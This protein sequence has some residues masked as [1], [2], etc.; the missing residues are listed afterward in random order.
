MTYHSMD[1][2]LWSSWLAPVVISK[3]QLIT[4]NSQFRTKQKVEFSFWNIFFFIWTTVAVVSLTKFR[5][6]PYTW[7]TDLKYEYGSRVVFSKSNTLF[8]VC[9]SSFW[10]PFQFF[11]RFSS[12]PQ[13]TMERECC[14]FRYFF[15]RKYKSSIYFFHDLS[16]CT[17]YNEIE[18]IGS[19]QIK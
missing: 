17:L 12:H 16:T 10:I 15:F 13:I 19:V 6:I 7:K 5:V 3:F 2:S 4:K 1:S 9:S 11:F 18:W 8:Y 14:L